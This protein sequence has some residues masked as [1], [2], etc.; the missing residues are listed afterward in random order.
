VLVELEAATWWHSSGDFLDLLPCALPKGCGPQS[1]GP[2]RPRRFESVG[3]RP[4]STA[5][6]ELGNSRGWKTSWPPGAAVGLCP[7]RIHGQLI[8]KFV[9]SLPPRLPTDACP[10]PPTPKHGCRQGGPTDESSANG[11]DGTLCWMRE[12]PFPTPEMSI[13]GKQTPIANERSPP[14]SPDQGLP[15]SPN[16]PTQQWTDNTTPSKTIDEAH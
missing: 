3:R 7:C 4:Q 1:R 12:R 9:P 13:G 6:A 14:N 16:H 8:K 2:P 15:W 11:T 5:G 10:I